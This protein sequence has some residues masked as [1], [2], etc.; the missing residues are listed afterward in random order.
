[1][2]VTNKKGITS[3]PTEIVDDLSPQLGGN[4]DVN[5]KEIISVGG[6]DI[7]LHSD[8]DV[9]VI[10]GDAAGVDDFNIKDSAGATVANINSNGG[11]EFNSVV[12][13]ASELEHLGDPDTQMTFATNRVSLFA[14]GSRGFD[15]DANNVILNQDGIQD[16]KM[17]TS[18]N[19]LAL[20][21]DNSADTINLNVATIALSITSSSATGGSLNAGNATSTAPSF[22][23]IKTD[24]DTG[25]GSAGAD[26][27]SVITGAVE[28]IRY[29]EN[30]GV[31]QTHQLNAG[32]TADSG[33]IQGGTPLTSTY[34]QIATCA[35]TGDSVTLPSAAAGNKVTIVNNGANACDVFPAS[36]DNLG[37]GADTAVSL[38]AGAN[39][40][41]IAYDTTNYFS[42]T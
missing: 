4:L 21:L 30:V 33:S 26:T 14:G 22:S 42:V 40:T 10:L 1:M 29:T 34:N 9:D 31:L 12:G 20:F 2:G 7:V 19:N 25:I 35:T 18:G 17:E 32:L 3:S 16:I 38:A 36:G 28:A 15:M 27:F 24:T 23:P 5:G 41:Y 8:N 39:I 37:A 6:T 13:I 11:A